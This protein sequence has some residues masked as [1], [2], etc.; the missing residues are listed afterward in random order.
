MPGVA[1]EDTDETELVP[2]AGSKEEENTE[3][4]MDPKKVITI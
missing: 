3:A 2:L 4:D 1:E